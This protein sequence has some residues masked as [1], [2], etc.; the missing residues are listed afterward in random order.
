MS[1]QPIQLTS[2]EQN[3]YMNKNN[4]GKNVNFTGVNPVIT[5][6]D[7]IDRGGFAASFILQD[8]LGMAAPRIGTGL[9]RNHDKTGH[10]NWDFA[11]KEGIREVLSGPSAF[12]I[13]LG[14]M[15]GIEKFAGAANNVP[16]DYING[17]GEEFAKF[18][19]ANKDLLK[20]PAKAK[21]GFYKELFKN[22]LS[23]STNG[24]LQGEE[25][26]KLSESYAKR[27]I[28]AENAKS[29]GFFRNLTG[30]KV[31]GS[32]QDLTQE[33]L[34]DFVKQRK[35]F[36][37]AEG[38]KTLVE[39][40]TSS[41]KKLTTSFKEVLGNM[42][43]YANDAIKSI[44]KK[45]KPD[46]DINKFVKNFSRRRSGS[47]FVANMSMF[48]AVVAFFTI[49]PKLYNHATKGKDPGLAGLVPEEDQKNGQVS[50]TGGM[51][52]AQ[53][54]FAKTG[55]AV[56]KNGLLKKLSDTFEFSGA[57]MSMPAMLTLLFGFCLPPRLVNAQSNTDRKEILFRDTLSFGSIL[58]GAKALTRVFSDVFAKLSGLALNIK[59]ENHNNS[60]LKKVWHYVYPS[61]GVQVLDSDRIIANYSDVEA[62]KNGLKDLFKFVDKNGGNVGKM[63][64]LDNNIKEAATTILGK[65]PNK[66]M[67]LADI[68]EKFEGAKGTEAYKKIVEVLKDQNNTLVKKAKTMNS[69]FGF[70]STILLVPAL[71][72]WISK[73]CENM[74]KQRVAEETRL[75]NAQKIYDDI[76]RD[77]HPTMAGFLNK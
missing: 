34:E 30:K 44:G 4:N 17:F 19:N 11:K 40:T 25:L 59:P 57:S 35:R 77:N 63:L 45:L 28:Q 1:V 16:I 62:S 3:R 74:T 66:D 24:G 68:I 39:F 14:M 46:L 42:N 64:T 50:F 32:A 61:G 60:I 18:A 27:L 69:A 75:K 22:M 37:G 31:P 33:L 38:D 20:E 65:V 52:T 29:K 41:G 73:H 21:Q 49:I 51:N 48:G 36:L 13:P 71:M 7:A 5:V 67:K 53:R 8:F 26:E 23:T 15:F 70:A 54:A 10:L 47:R 56:V 76:M 72:M 43:D 58:F 12:L 2:A 55:D 9:Y 6:M